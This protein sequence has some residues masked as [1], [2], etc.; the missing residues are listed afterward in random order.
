MGLGRYREGEKRIEGFI[1][2]VMLMTGWGED[3]R[4]LLRW[5]VGAL[6]CFFVMGRVMGQDKLHGNETRV[7]VIG[8]VAPGGIDGEYC[9]DAVD[10]YLMF[11]EHMHEI[12]AKRTQWMMMQTMNESLP[13]DFNLRIFESVDE[14]KKNHA[15]DPVH[16]LVGC[17]GWKSDIAT[18]LAEFSFKHSL[19][20][21]RCCSPEDLTAH[22]S[23]R[24]IFDMQPGSGRFVELLIRSLVL[25]SIVRF[26]VVY[27]EDNVFHT[28]TC[29]EA[30]KLI[31]DYKDVVGEFIPPVVVHYNKTDER[32]GIAAELFPG[33]ATEGALQGIEAVIACLDEHDSEALVKSF[34]DI[35]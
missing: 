20:L 26:A 25:R 6:F 11:I 23:T 1:Y 15:K 14:L 12:R 7:F 32:P 5:W 21:L 8:M 18:S 19:I 24:N 33:V 2:R 27:E 28:N 4:W 34:D 31:N 16:F 3:R 10:G 13:F 29:S 22:D 17:E 35:R 30:I 9:R